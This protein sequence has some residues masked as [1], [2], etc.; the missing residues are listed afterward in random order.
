MIKDYK[1]S[2]D[3]WEKAYADSQKKTNFD[4]T[5]EVS[6]WQNLAPSEKFVSALSS[7]SNCQKVLD[8]GCGE[9]WGSI[10]MA[11]TGCKNITSVELS[12]SAIQTTIDNSKKYQ[13]NNYINAFVISKDWINKE[14]SEKYDGFFCS[15][16]IDVVPEEIAD[17][18]LKQAHRIVKPSFR[19]I[20]SLNFYLDT[21]LNANHNHEVKGNYL[22]RDGILRM[23]NRTNQEWSNIFSK[24][25]KVEKIEHFAWPNEAKETRR[26]YYLINK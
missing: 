7:F 19:L 9:G 5:N 13:V 15:N 14:E 12:K 16:V 8:Y 3:F 2:L 18:I 17:N 4:D 6:N 21:K 11:K 22:Y 26:L 1:N 10:I 25:F 23:V 20:I 24:Y